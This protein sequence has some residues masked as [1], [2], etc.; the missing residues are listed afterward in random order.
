MVLLGCD[1]PY[2]CLKGY[3]FKKIRTFIFK[4]LDKFKLYQRF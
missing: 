3:K 2:H 1:D 4:L